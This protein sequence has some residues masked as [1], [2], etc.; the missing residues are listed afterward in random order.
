MTEETKAG[1]LKEKM[2]ISWSCFLELQGS[3]IRKYKTQTKQT[4]NIVA[5]SRKMLVDDSI[6]RTSNWK[7]DKDTVN[8]LL[9]RRATE[10]E[11][12][13]VK[14]EDNEEGYGSASETSYDQPCGNEPVG[15]QKGRW[16]VGNREGVKKKKNEITKI[17]KS[18]VCKLCT[19]TEDVDVR[20]LGTIRLMNW[21]IPRKEF[22]M[23]V[24]IPS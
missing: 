6:W 10:P 2:A 1:F 13:K 5:K 16:S 11:V 4:T 7:K 8:K 17:E 9:K 21:K 14:E 20:V 3:Y 12:V 19:K 24:G 22:P 15:K 18:R 23:R